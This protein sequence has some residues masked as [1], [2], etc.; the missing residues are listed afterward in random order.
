LKFINFFLFFYWPLLLPL[1]PL[2]L[3]EPPLIL[4]M[5][6]PVILPPLILL[7]ALPPE[8]DALVE[9]PCANTEPTTNVDTANAATIATIAIKFN[10]DMQC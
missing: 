10:L 8:L 3:F 2:L 7:L 4:V 5:F 1:L 9:L 6:M